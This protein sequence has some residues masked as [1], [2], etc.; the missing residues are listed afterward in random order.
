MQK[1]KITDGNRKVVRLGG[2]KDRCCRRI[3]SEQLKAM[4]EVD[5]RTVDKSTLVEIGEVEIDTSLPDEERMLDF[6]QQ[7]KNPYCYLDHG[8]VVKISFS[9][10]RRLEDCLNSCVRPK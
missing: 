10:K 7:V 3:I 5:I 9:G 4:Q 1:E 2:N 6:V 8:T